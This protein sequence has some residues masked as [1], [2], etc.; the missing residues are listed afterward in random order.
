[1]VT[2]DPRT[3]ALVFGII[4]AGEVGSQLARSFI[5]AGHR[6]V[7]ANSRGPHTLTALVERLGDSARAGTATEA[8]EAGD[9]VVIAAP[10][11]QVNTIPAEPLQGK[12][13]IDTNNHMPWRDGVFPEVAN[14]ELTVHEMRQR[15]LPAAF[16]TKAFTHIQA[17]RIPLSAS[18]PGTP[19]R[20]AL[21]VS[22]DQPGAVAFVTALHDQI[23]FD[24]VDNSPL[25][26]SWRTE[27]GQPAWNAHMHQTQ[28]E[29]RANLDA[30]RPSGIRAAHG[31]WDD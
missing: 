11:T 9:V 14:G 23:G 22:S 12:I 26:E 5:A 17:P 21:S 4:G 28:A 20:H 1:M 10:L 31:R 27:P 13:V 18:P 19:G 24:T 7:I 29:L 2:P 8:A 25:S 15:H 6:V 30:A 3:T 16:V